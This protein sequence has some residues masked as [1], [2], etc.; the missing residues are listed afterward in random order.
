MLFF[1]KFEDHIEEVWDFTPI[2]FDLETTGLGPT[3]EI[4]EIAAW[5]LDPKLVNIPNEYDEKYKIRD[6]VFYSLILPTKRMNSAASKVNGIKKL[7]RNGLSVRGVKHFNLEGQKTVMQKF[8]K[9][10][11]SIKNPILIAHNC[12]R[13]IYT[14]ITLIQ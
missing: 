10:L 12:F 2:I 6:D 8:I 9:W 4:I 1:R 7:G 11:M 14:Q 3:C 5:K 13:S